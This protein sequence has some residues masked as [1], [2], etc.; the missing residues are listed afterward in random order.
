MNKRKGGKVMKNN[1]VI[2]G[3]TAVVHSN[4]PGDDRG[5]FQKIIKEMEALKDTLGFELVTINEPLTSEESGANAKK[6]LDDHRVDFTLV[7]N[8]S[9]GDGRTI[10]PLARVNS[11]LGLW[12][13]PEPALEGVLQLN[14]I[15]G[16]NMYT[17]IIANYLN[18]YNIPFKWFYGFPDNKLFLERFKVSLKAIKAI[19][20]LR[21]A[22]IGLIGDIA[23]GFENFN[24]D[25]RAPEQKFGTYIN[26]RHSVEDIVR[27]AEGYNDAQVNQL[28][29]RIQA[30]GAWRKDRVGAE[31]M[32]KSARINLALADFVT[33]NDYDALAIS[34]WPKFQ[35]VYG[36]AVCSVLSRLNESGIVAACEGDVPGA[37]NMLIYNA[38]TGEKSTMMDL[39]A[40]D[41]KD[42]SICMWHCGPTAASLADKNGVTW[43]A[44]FNIGHYEGNKWCGSGVVADLTF[45]PGQVT[46]SRINSLFDRLLVM[47]GEVMEHKKGFAGSSGWINNLEIGGGKLTIADYINTLVVNRVDHHHQIA[48]GD[49]TNELYEIANWMKLKILDAVPYQTYMQDLT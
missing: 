16:L 41:E 24:F 5:A 45:K 20:T 6:I 35:Q 21:L 8:A 13:I 38:I 2:V 22:R 1:K 25:E 37:M 48:Y 26:R 18:E 29:E 17:A 4:M 31:F 10:L 44:H 30:E 14:S 12:S 47:T 46:I 19:K 27:R 42:N 39:S 33:E 23:Y 32:R 15:C 3:L 36:L 40:L 43:D 28:L 9:L 34:C 49:L 11:F 7:L